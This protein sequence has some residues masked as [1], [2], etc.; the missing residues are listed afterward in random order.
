MALKPQL[1]G[2]GAPVKRAGL[3]TLIV[4]A[5]TLGGCVV[6]PYGARRGYRRPVVAVVA[7]APVVGIR[8]Y[9]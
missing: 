9:R 4:L 6:V 7:P 3:G 5:L 1:R 2:G 8:V